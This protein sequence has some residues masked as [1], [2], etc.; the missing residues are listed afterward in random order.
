MRKSAEEVLQKIDR[1]LS[2]PGN[3]EIASSLKR[4]KLKIEE[5]QEKLNQKQFSAAFIGKIGA[6]KTS[7]IC[8]I[9]GLIDGEGP[10]SVDLLKTGAGRTTL[11]EVIIEHADQYSIKIEPLPP[12]EVQCLVNFFSQQTWTETHNEQQQ[13]LEDPLS[14][15]MKRCLKNILQLPRTSKQENGRRVYTETSLTLAQDFNSA[16]QFNEALLSRLNLEK[17]TKTELRFSPGDGKNWKQWLKDTFSEINDGKNPQVSIPARIIICGPFSLTQ[18]SCT[19]KFIDT[20]GIDSFVHRKDLREILDTDGIFPVVCSSFADA[21][22]ADSRSFYDLGIQLGVRDRIVRD[23]SLLVLDRNEAT[24]VADIDDE[25]TSPSERR[26]EGRSIRESQINSRMNNDFQLTPHQLIFDSRFDSATR[27]WEVLQAR[28]QDYLDSK[29]QEL[30]TLLSAS[31]E[32]LNA[33]INQFEQFEED[34]RTV[35]FRQLKKKVL[36]WEHLGQ[37]VQRLLA[38]AHHST[39]AASI[40]RRGDW[41]KLDIYESVNQLARAKAVLL[42]HEDFVTLKTH[43]KELKKKYP[44][45]SHQL[46]ALEEYSKAKLH[47]FSIH[48]GEIAEKLWIEQVKPAQE[49]WH[50]MSQERGRGA[51]YKDRVIQHWQNWFRREFAR[52]IHEVLLERVQALWQGVATELQGAPAELLGEF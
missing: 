16:E 44:Q 23:T 19:W 38:Q 18:G 51:G 17:R 2:A 31:E 36:V 12:D 1:Y 50:N 43:F 46:D 34:V 13:Q 32:I 47:L 30:Q 33:E 29:A 42:C 8:K 52:R 39:L 35:L 22:D 3:P 14:E 45:F 10:E 4:N 48:T 11:C 25:I 28:Q 24:Q 5:L 7:A 15:E 26:Q 41:H 27:F 6:G 9:L 20:R 37:P 21:P 49:P 40:D